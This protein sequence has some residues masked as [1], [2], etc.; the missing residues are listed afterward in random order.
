MLL[1]V[2]SPPSRRWSPAPPAST[3]AAVS[4]HLGTAAREPLFMYQSDHVSLLRET[5]S[6][7]PCAQSTRPS[8]IGISQ[9]K[10]ALI[11]PLTIPHPCMLSALQPH[12]SF[13]PQGLGTGWSL[14]HDALPA[15]PRS[16][17]TPP[18]PPTPCIHTA[19]ALTPFGS[20]LMCHFFKITFPVL[21]RNG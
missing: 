14:C 20:L 2:Q 19:K 18:P 5:P 15:A 3:L 7:I 9:Q 11:S 4:S 17:P 1:P 10:A 12:G 16:A 8:R 6:Q 13:L 21:I